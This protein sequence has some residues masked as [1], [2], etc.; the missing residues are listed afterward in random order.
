MREARMVIEIPF[1]V[2]MLQLDWGLPRV[3]A[4]SL[5]AQP[6]TRVHYMHICGMY[7]LSCE[8]GRISNPKWYAVLPV[9]GILRV[10]L[11][12]QNVMHAW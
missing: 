8:P 3:T 10:V 4:C 1:C 9:N 2:V 6:H 12:V 11:L 5:L 7:Y